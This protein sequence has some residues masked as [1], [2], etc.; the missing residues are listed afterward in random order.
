MITF[1]TYIDY[2]VNPDEDSLGGQS[3][4]LI[5]TSNLHLEFTDTQVI[6]TG[7]G[8]NHMIPREYLGCLEAG[9]R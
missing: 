1:D 8:L 3:H 6:L 9:L 7:L 5:R 2:L 4:A